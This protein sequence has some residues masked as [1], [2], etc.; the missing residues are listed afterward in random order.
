MT[1]DSIS[2]RKPNVAQ[3]KLFIREPGINQIMLRNI[4]PILAAIFLVVITNTDA[5]VPR[6][7]VSDEQTVAQAE[8]V[9]SGTYIEIYQH[10]ATIDPSFLRVMESAYEQV[11]RVTGLKLDTATL[12]PR[13][14]VYVSDAIGV[15]H[16]WRGYQHPTDPK[17]IIFL[18]LRVYQ[19]AMSGKNATHVHELTHLFT[20]RYNSHTL[21]EGIADYV[22]LKIL[23]GA[24][25]GPN[26]GG[27]AAPLAISPEVVEYLGTTKPPPEWVSTDPLRR[28]AYYFASYRLVKYL[29][30]TKDMETF[31]KLYTSENPEIDIKSL[32][33]LERK[34]AVE[35]ALG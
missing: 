17:A 14:R 9:A 15:S 12:G 35:A 20:W 24:A 7:S 30:E 18:N 31:W 28:G 19:G 4:G 32:Y 27:D 8:L 13:V 16:V 29:I 11:Q 22:A 26:P 23:P 25:V 3:Q 6:R 1:V 33:G 2:T 21:R 34:E 5:A 10:G